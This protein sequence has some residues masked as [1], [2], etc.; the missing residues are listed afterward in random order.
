MCNLSILMG[1]SNISGDMSLDVT[2]SYT[3][4]LT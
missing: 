1:G 3:S 2:R 4:T